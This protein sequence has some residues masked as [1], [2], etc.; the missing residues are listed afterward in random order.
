MPPGFKLIVYYQVRTG[1]RQEWLIAT[2]RLG[3]G[4]GANII[5]I[6]WLVVCPT[7]SSSSVLN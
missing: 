7:P 2:G 5:W 6:I 3:V 1:F 4:N